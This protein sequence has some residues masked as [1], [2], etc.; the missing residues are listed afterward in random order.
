MILIWTQ[1]SKVLLANNGTFIS[2][3]EALPVLIFYTIVCNTYW[4]KLQ[5]SGDGRQDTLIYK[6]GKSKHT[7]QIFN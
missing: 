2:S 6:T 4:M 5:S 3:T 1:S 7:F